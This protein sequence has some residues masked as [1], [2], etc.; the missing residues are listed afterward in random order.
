MR[1]EHEDGSVPGLPEVYRLPG[2]PACVHL[3]IEF[4]PHAVLYQDLSSWLADDGDVEW[5]SEE[6]RARALAL[7][8]IWLCQWYPR[9]P[10]GFCR[11]AAS[12][13]VALMAACVDSA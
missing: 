12:S 3:S 5:V 10:V 1:V 4:N 9:T 11:L 6:E 13:F 8:T 2:F 7:N